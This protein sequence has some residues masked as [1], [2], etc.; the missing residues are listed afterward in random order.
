MLRLARKFREIAVE[1]GGL[2]IKVGQFL[3]SRLDVL[4]PEITAELTGL[5]DEVPP[6]PFAEIRSLA[7][8]ELGASLEKV[9]DWFDEVP[10]AA[11]SLGQA[12]RARLSDADVADTGFRDVVV[13]VQRPGIDDIVAVDLAALRKIAER[14]R[15]IRFV[16]DRVD[17]PALVE[18]FAQTSLDEVD[19][20]KEAANA[21]R[22]TE[23]FAHDVRVGAPEI[24]WERTTRKVLTLSDVTAIKINDVDALQAA[25][26]DPAAVAETFA[27]IMFEQVFAHGFF[28]GDPHPGNIFITPSTGT[29]A[30]EQPWRVTFID[31]GMMGEIPAELRGALRSAVLAV[32]ARDGK[33]LVAAAQ[34][35]GVVLPSANTAEF[36]RTMT[37]LFARFGGM[38]VSE[39]AALDPSELRQFAD[40]FGE[41]IRSLPFQLPEGLLLLFR[42]MSLTSGVCSGLNRDF[43]VWDVVEPYATRLVREEAGNAVADVARQAWT[44]VERLW[45]LPQRLDALTT[46]IDQGELTFDTSQLEHRFD[47]LERIGR[48]AVAAL[49]FVGFLLGGVFLLPVLPALGI[50]LMVVSV[51]P[52]VYAVSTGLSRWNGRPPVF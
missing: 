9:F 6:V 50:V 18:E 23:N 7:E 8:A 45:R 39:V 19:Y 26:I 51:P 52:F 11:A 1:L 17:A 37:A 31:F 15:R 48:G 33:K 41:T 10:L 49:L 5:Q 3:S 47:R 38:G 40:E 16:S 30:D 36:E 43:N 44:G 32:A 22:F 12:H 35:V 20:L 34:Q 21:A 28:H 27:D 29:D 42:A 25:G 2:M 24:A 14:S 4:P 13:K 46:K